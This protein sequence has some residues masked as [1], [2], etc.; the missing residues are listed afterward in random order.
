MLI[1]VKV[2]GVWSLGDMGTGKVEVEGIPPGSR[3]RVDILQAAEVN[4]L[5]TEPGY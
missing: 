4:V 1:D 3:C 5:L 2:E